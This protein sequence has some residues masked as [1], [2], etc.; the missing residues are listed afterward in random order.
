MRPGSPRLFPELVFRPPVGP[1]SHTRVKVSAAPCVSDL[2]AVLTLGVSVLGT[3]FATFGRQVH[4]RESARLET[5]GL[6][7]GGPEL[8]GLGF[9]LWTDIRASSLWPAVH[10]WPGLG[11]DVVVPWCLGREAPSGCERSSLESGSCA[12]QSSSQLFFGWA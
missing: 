5:G 8:Q 3:M 10:P 7:A 4:G 1:E 9:V 12:D 6:A 11:E 2:S